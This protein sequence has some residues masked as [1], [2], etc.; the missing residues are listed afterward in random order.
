MDLLR[1]IDPQRICVLK[2]HSKDDVLAEIIACAAKAG[3]PCDREELK[4]RIYYREKLMSTG[5]G[6]GIGLPHVRMEGITEPM[7]TIGLQP[8]GIIGYESIDGL[9]IKIVIM[10]LVGR[11]QHKQHLELLSKI[12]TILK[13]SRIIDALLSA[14]T[15]D[16]AYQVLVKEIS[17][18]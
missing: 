2:H 1:A 10:I 7:I 13:R 17:H 11:D 18:V 8:D 16:D 4:E 6:L 15:P 3:L 9:P 12:V 5:I 14:E